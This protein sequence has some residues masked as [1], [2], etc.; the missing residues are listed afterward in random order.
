MSV[1][2]STPKENDSVKVI[3]IKG[4]LDMEMSGQLEAQARAAHRDGVRNL[5]IDMTDVPY[6]S[7][8]GLRTLHGLFELLRA[9]S[10]AESSEAMRKGLADGTFKSPHLK[11]LNP[12]TRVREVLK[13]S[14]Y[15]MF[16]EI[17]SNL[18]EAVASFK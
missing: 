1:T 10:P 17:H 4:D 12:S 6:M 18:A 5:L 15:D 9:D 8:A 14:G 3:K 7:S 2:V 11:L 16:L 13:I